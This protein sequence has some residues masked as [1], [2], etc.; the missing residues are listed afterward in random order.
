MYF[1]DNDEKRYEKL[2][3]A[4]DQAL[5]RARV[6]LPK[7]LRADGIRKDIES[8]PKK[9]ERNDP[10]LAIVLADLRKEVCGEG[11]A[12]QIGI[13]A[14]HL[15]EHV[16]RQVLLPAPMK[17]HMHDDTVFQEL[18]NRNIAPWIIGYLNL[19]RAF[20]NEGAHQGGPATMKR[21]PPQIK[22]HDLIVCLLAIDRILD[23]WFWFRE[24]IN[25]TK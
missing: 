15:R 21:Y 18:R 19:L 16:I 3:S 11:R 25:E 24:N 17:P 12:S 10:E 9:F 20:G 22:D 7:S 23:F 14:R 6:T 1:V 5:D 8:W 4:M 2:K 13:A